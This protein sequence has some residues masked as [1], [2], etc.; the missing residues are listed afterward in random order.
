MKKVSINFKQRRWHSKTMKKSTILFW[1]FL[2]SF[3][4]CILSFVFVFFNPYSQVNFLSSTAILVILFT[5]IPSII[6][7][8][9]LL[10]GKFLLTMI[11]CIFLTPMCLYLSVSSIPSI[12]NLYGV[13]LIILIISALML[14]KAH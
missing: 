8:L 7:A 4:I 2:S 3:I 6:A 11:C 9:S 5:I 10:I 1:G 13:M 14:K 12:W